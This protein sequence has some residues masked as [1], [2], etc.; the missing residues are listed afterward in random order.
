MGDLFFLFWTMNSSF[1]GP[2]DIKS[3]KFSTA[4]DVW[5]SRY[6][7]SNLVLT[8]DSALVLAFVDFRGRCNFKATHGGSIV[9]SDDKKIWS[10]LHS[11]NKSMVRHTLAHAWHIAISIPERKP[12]DVVLRP[13]WA[14]THIPQEWL[15]SEHLRGVP[16]QVVNNALTHGCRGVESNLATIGFKPSIN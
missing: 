5:F 13:W 14:N 15:N 12:C 10:C 16:R 8:T 4:Y 9:I 2:C 11:Q 6:R 3:V 1:K 7:P